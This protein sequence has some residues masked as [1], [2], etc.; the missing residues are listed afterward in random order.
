MRNRG[1]Y[2]LIASGVVGSAALGWGLLSN[3]SEAE[4]TVAAQQLPETVIPMVQIVVASRDIVQGETISLSNLTLADWPENDLP[5]GA[6]SSFNALDVSE[7]TTRKALT[8]ISSGAPVLSSRLS[9]KG[10]QSALSARLNPG[11]RAFSIRIDEV[12]GVAGFVLPG[13]RVDV[14]HTYKNEGSPTSTQVLLQNVEVLAVDRNDDLLSED[15]ELAK[16][17]TLAVNLVQAQALSMAAQ[18]G[19]L[20]FALVGK[21]ETTNGANAKPLTVSAAPSESAVRRSTKPL[22]KQSP[23]QTIALTP[24]KTNSTVNVILGDD[25]VEE[26]V[27]TG[28]AKSG[29]TLSA[30]STDKTG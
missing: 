4:P 22:P 17:A 29:Y 13:T 12:S 19:R 20:S 6:Y 2:M 11:M 8:D 7:D 1:L 24:V 25:R 23:K 21:A 10:G 18:D 26:N 30:I 3:S 14:L 5:Y 27:P 28:S 15:P 9:I 16:T